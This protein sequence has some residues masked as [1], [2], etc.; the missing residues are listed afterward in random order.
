ML[1]TE[2]VSIHLHSFSHS[3]QLCEYFWKDNGK[4]KPVLCLKS[5]LLILGAFLT[6]TAK[7]NTVKNVSFLFTQHLYKSLKFQMLANRSTYKLVRERVSSVILGEVMVYGS[8]LNWRGGGCN[9]Q[10]EPQSRAP[11]GLYSAWHI[12]FSVSK[13]FKSSE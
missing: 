12:D 10:E 6:I 1:Y 3:L 2:I 9:H 5:C 4:T 8:R 13:E 11:L 7:S